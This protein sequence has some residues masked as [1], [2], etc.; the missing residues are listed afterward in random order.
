MFYH[1]LKLRIVS[2]LTA[3]LYFLGASRALNNVKE[4]KEVGTK[5][6]YLA[7][8]CYRNIKVKYKQPLYSQGFFLS[9]SSCVLYDH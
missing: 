3:T 2:H 1:L 7:K 5:F 4:K 8:K 9:I 6:L